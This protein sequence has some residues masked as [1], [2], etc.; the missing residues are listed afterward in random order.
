MVDN[1]QCAGYTFYSK[2][3]SGNLGRVELV[4]C[5]D[6]LNIVGN[7]ASSSSLPSASSTHVSTGLLLS[8][9][10][11]QAP[12]QKFASGGSLVIIGANSPPA[13]IE[14][15]TPCPLS[16]LSQQ[17]PLGPS[18]GAAS[19]AVNSNSITTIAPLELHHQLLY[20]SHH[21]ASFVEVEFNL[22][23][24]PDCAGT[25]YENQ[26]RTWFYFAV[27][28]GRPHQ[29][30]KFN[31]MNLNK[32]AKL[33]SQG[34]HPV[35]KVGP[36]G[37]W[38]RTK[39]KPSY[40][41]TNDVFFISFLHRAPDSPETKTYYAFT[42][43]FSY[44]DLLEQLGNFDKRF[45]RHPFEL[46]QIAHEVAQQFEPTT[47]PAVVEA[48]PVSGNS[49][50]S[51]K[52]KLVKECKVERC[53]PESLDDTAR[54]GT[55]NDEEDLSK[56]NTVGANGSKH[57][58]DPDLVSAMSIDD[59]TSESMQQITNLVKGVNI[60]LQ[61]QPS[62]PSIAE[63]SK[64]KLP[65]FQQIL[66]APAIDDEGK[67]SNVDLRDDIYYYREL[68]T[69]SV[70]RRRIELLTISSFHGIQTV[71]EERLRNLFPDEKTPR[72]HTFKNKK[73]IFISSRVHPGETPASFVLNGFLSMLLDRKS[74]VSITL[75]RMYVFKI[76][77]FLNP[78]GVYNGLY[79]SDT[80]GH[81][82]NRVYL[83][84]NCETQPA[85]YAA[86]KLIRYYHLGA[87]DPEPYELEIEKKIATLI[88]TP[89]TSSD[90]NVIASSAEEKSVSPAEMA[91]APKKG[92][93]SK[94]N[95]QKKQTENMQY[96]MSRLPKL[97]LSTAQSLI[98]TSSDRRKGRISSIFKKGSITTP[99]TSATP[100]SGSSTWPAKLLN[101]VFRRRKTVENA[102]LHQL[103]PISRRKTSLA[104]APVV[105]ET[106]E[107][108]RTVPTETSRPTLLLLSQTSSLIV[109]ISQ[110]LEKNCV[111]DSESTEENTPSTSDSGFG[112][113]ALSKSSTISKSSSTITLIETESPMVTTSVPT[114]MTNLTAT[115][116]DDVPG[117]ATSNVRPDGAASSETGS[118]ATT[119][120]VLPAPKVFTE[121]LIPELLPIVTESGFGVRPIRS[122]SNLSTASS[123]ANA[124]TITHVS[125][126]KTPMVTA[127][128]DTGRKTTSFKNAP[129]KP[130]LLAAAFNV[131]KKK[132]FAVS[133]TKQQSYPMS[134]QQ[135]SSLGK[136]AGTG[137]K[138][139]S[140][141]HHKRGETKLRPQT[142]QMYSHF[143]SHRNEYLNPAGQKSINISLDYLAQLD[144]KIDKSL[145][146][147]K[148]NMFLYIDLHG[149]A[150]KK[151][152]FMYGNHLPSTIE[153]VECMLLPRL[154]S[155]NSQ[156]FH[157]DA[158]NFSERNMYY[159]GKRDGLSKEGS[160]RVAIYKCTGLIKSYTLECNY[161]T[162]KSVN[163]LPLKGKET[164]STK[165]QSP[166][167][168]KYTPAV[169]EEVGRALGPSILDLTNSNP[170]SRLPNS[171][172]RTLQGLRN[173]LRIEIE[174]GSS[175]ARV[176]N[177]VPKPHSKRLSQQSS[178]SM[179]IA[180][181]NAI[182]WENIAGA[183]TSS[184]TGA[185]GCSS[186]GTG[187]AGNGN[188]KLNV[189]GEPLGGNG[190]SSACCS[191]A[192]S[193]GGRQFLKSG[194]LKAHSGKISRKGAGVGGK[195]FGKKD[196]IKK[197][198]I[199][200]ESAVGGAVVTGSK[201][202]QEIIRSKDQHQVP[203][204][205]I[206]V[207]PPH[208]HGAA[209]DGFDICFKTNLSATSLPN[210]LTNPPSLSEL[211]LSKKVK[212]E[213]KLLDEC[214][215]CDDSLDAIPCCS[216]SLPTTTSS[217]TVVL[218]KLMTTYPQVGSPGM[219]VGTNEL[220]PASPGGAGATPS[221]VATG[222][223]IA[224]AGSSS[225][226]VDKEPTKE[227]RFSKFSKATSAK[228][229]AKLGKS[230]KSSDGGK[231]LKKKRSLK[232]DSNLKRKKTRIKPALT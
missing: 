145:Y 168:P 87:D 24:R 221:N 66:H 91:A 231:M 177:K 215:E 219:V 130:N 159:K 125:I 29:I 203:R 33:F 19:S 220:L 105:E 214:L 13:Q 200:C 94:Q 209:D 42:F 150:S 140:T 73:I 158:C 38:E 134:Q 74:I 228:Q 99:S 186:T 78:D 182:Q 193:S 18:G 229:Q 103:P 71:R 183:Q 165:V 161:N 4:R 39:D 160:G 96:T 171:E 11:P 107:P 109:E 147:E 167:P 188:G 76:V 227:S 179:E 85:I 180:K 82:L 86:R 195:V 112:E 211:P 25:P 111:D 8:A 54:D 6:G 97:T 173:T 226:G 144:E 100:S 202:L 41:V 36:G 157:Y 23:T 51:K 15:A 72:C 155:I 169:F 205:K 122:A 14:T 198:K 64:I 119:E 57:V 116:T 210:F 58:E 90:E 31:V 60:E 185:G 35:M 32:Q 30:V 142:Q 45:G 61:P 149:H 196:A 79:R 17:L 52:S 139:T 154:M 191:S 187:V 223:S 47:D 143:R 102:R 44:N 95:A 104:L 206:K 9:S 132:D 192:A 101:K 194:S 110:S 56:V 141:L 213:S 121:Q 22:W 62:K 53:S 218:T 28:G 12:A 146:E 204:K 68:L 128:V 37:R 166:V 55:G 20:Q 114:V 7:N 133:H 232:T 65:F 174:R 208:Q 131:I 118:L 88:K 80:R 50:L 49:G 216:Y 93:I 117:S 217:N 106:V 16:P 120:E 162:G 178:S 184:V 75:R 137:S 207:S 81:N 190:N 124:S 27:T 43:P 26:N 148:S 89:N 84:P 98:D 152:V 153:A 197:S 172:F 113:Q 21:H 181:E 156:H 48:T 70:E 151:G 164:P 34:M 212:S 83:A 199:L 46:H 189:V 5:C 127:K 123:M 108:E 92:T 136:L 59:S 225:S 129:N 222:I 170:Q 3:D 67:I 115:T 224:M 2:F 63:S 40:A 230:T 135:Q 77:P 10:S 69:H 175:K 201:K 176:T 138:K 126:K 1:F 163:I